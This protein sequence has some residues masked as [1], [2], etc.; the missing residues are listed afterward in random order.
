MDNKKNFQHKDGFFNLLLPNTSLI[1]VRAMARKTGKS[2]VQIIG[3]AI[4]S[5]AERILTKEDLEQ[6]ARELKDSGMYD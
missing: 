6:V 3:V 4:Q 2:F 1:I 5:L